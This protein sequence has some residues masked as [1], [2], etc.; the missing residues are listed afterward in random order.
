M[1]ALVQG[2]PPLGYAFHQVLGFRVWVCLPS[3]R[4]KQPENYFTLNSGFMPFT[5]PMQYGRTD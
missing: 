1:K 3:G 2:S 5:V 4:Y